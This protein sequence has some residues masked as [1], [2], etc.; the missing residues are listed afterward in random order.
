MI[1]RIKSSFDNF[2]KTILLMSEETNIKNIAAHENVILTKVLGYIEIISVLFGSIL[3]FYWKFGVA[4]IILFTSSILV[5][6]MILFMLPKL[7]VKE[8]L[9]KHIIG[10]VLSMQFIINYFLFYKHI[11]TILWLVMV[12]F[13][14]PTS[15]SISHTVLIYLIM[16]SCFVY[17]LIYLRAAEEMILVETTFRLT[18][19][20]MV[21][22]IFII[23]ILANRIYNSMIQH[24][25]A[26]Y[27]N[28][29][30]QKKE[31]K[32]LYEKA[33]TSE[34][35][36]VQKNEE[37]NHLA[38]TDIL[39]ALPNRRKAL[40]ILE[41]LIKG[42]K[43]EYL[44]LVSTDLDNFKKIND[45]LGHSMGDKLLMAVSER[46]KN[47][48][49]KNDTLCSLGGDEFALIIRNQEDNF[50]VYNY[51]RAILD[52]IIQPFKIDNYEMTISA[53]MGV[54]I[55]PTDCNNTL[56]FIK[57][58]NI[59]MHNAKIRGRND[60]FFY[61]SEHKN[62]MLER[63]KLENN[64][65]TA[66]DYEELYMVYQPIIDTKSGSPI[67]FEALMRWTPNQIPSVGPNV[68]IPLME[69]LGIIHKIGMWAFREVCNKIV[70]IKKNYGIDMKFFVNISPTQLKKKSYIYDLRKIIQESKINPNLLCFEITETVFIDNLENA[71]MTIYALKELG[72][73]IA[74][75]DFGTG[76]S[77]LSY[78][79]N[80]PIDVLKI[81][82]SFIDLI[83]SG[84]EG[85]KKISLAI[86]NM[87]MSLN[88][89][90]IAEGVETASQNEFLSANK[91]DMVQ[92]YYH[93]MPMN[94]MEMKEYC[95]KIFLDK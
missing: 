51:L 20:T 42:G 87:A 95:D 28:L 27:L 91:C 93:S 41:E 61:E 19:N 24:K 86:L 32:E 94:S 22:F 37:L 5:G 55:W 47:S 6:V 50:D 64:L 17:F 62:S 77:S 79:V 8:P 10:I 57:Y 92:G 3:C 75:D 16:T 7:N 29:L 76:Y 26:Q 63:M 88:L 78:L 65:T 33:N 69:D 35:E 82:K 15:I 12:I 1:N 56:D 90:V 40:L 73:K 54:A 52:I 59:A 44:Y 38:H 70:E 34:E 45:T 30:R 60:I 49:N 18:S 71:L 13:A 68:F 25:N 89:K 9:K 43:D 21:A 23:L 58:A 2:L 74:I 39:T 72:I 84:G 36:L 66:L 53:S 48:I 31:L 4:E 80:L 11:T 67:A 46:F 85:D 81:D 14:I 83:D